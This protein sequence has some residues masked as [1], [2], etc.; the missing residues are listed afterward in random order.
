METYGVSQLSADVFG[1]L[2]L[3]TPYDIDVPKIRVGAP[4]DGGYVMAQLGSGGDLLSFGIANDVRFEMEMA[5]KGRRCFMYDHTIDDLPH[6]HDKFVF[7]KKGICGDGHRTDDLLSLG[8]CLGSL[9]CSERLLLKMDVEGAEW[10]VF[11]T[12]SDEV[13][14]RFDQIVGEFH[15][16]LELGNERFRTRFCEAMTRLNKHFTLFHVHANNCRTLGL[17]NGFA[18]ADV[19]ELSF[20]RT[21]LIGRRP[22]ATV[23]PTP[24]DRAN[25]HMVDDHALFFYPFLPMAVDASVVTDTIVRIKIDNMHP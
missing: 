17:V 10:D 7:F 2:S 19:L 12:A 9:P 18:V 13:L 6:R 8:E 22:S 23:Y 4:R 20:V 11:S 21:S 14:S 3:L 25:N 5:I 1:A 24:L 16:L 15:W